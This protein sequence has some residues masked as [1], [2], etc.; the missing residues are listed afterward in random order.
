MLDVIEDNSLFCDFIR[1]SFLL[2]LSKK[3]ASCLGR[4]SEKVRLK[5]TVHGCDKDI[6]ILA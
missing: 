2:L 3:V 6:I 1:D 5:T 4:L